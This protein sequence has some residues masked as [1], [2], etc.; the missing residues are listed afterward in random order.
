MIQSLIFIKT[1]LT[2]KCFSFP[3]QH[4]F[5]ELVRWSEPMRIPRSNLLFFGFRAL[6]DQ[7]E[8]FKRE[9][10]LRWKKNQNRTKVLA[11]RGENRL[12]KIPGWGKN[13]NHSNMK[14][15]LTRYRSTLLVQIGLL[16]VDLLINTFCEYLRFESVILLVV[17]M[18]VDAIM[19]CG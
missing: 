8:V 10:L 14:L 7:Q 5:V 11:Q 18:W 16:L 6:H 2:E 3:R 1:K 9:L 19:G 15:S 17:F 4:Y 13:K 12:L